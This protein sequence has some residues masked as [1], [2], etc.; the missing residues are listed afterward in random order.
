MPKVYLRCV[1][2]YACLYKFKTNAY[3]C[4]VRISNVGF[5]FFFNMYLVNGIYIS[6]CSRDLEKKYSSLHNACITKV[7]FIPVATNCL[8][9]YTF[10][11]WTVY[12]EDGRQE[13]KTRIHF[14]TMTDNKNNI[15]VIINSIKLLLNTILLAV[16]IFIFI[17]L[18]NI[19]NL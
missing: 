9:I 13:R 14:S 17:F 4:L 2:V 10:I 6:V 12:V 16:I 7:D 11:S 18:N 8:Y 1:C 19:G 5:F 3:Y 15:A